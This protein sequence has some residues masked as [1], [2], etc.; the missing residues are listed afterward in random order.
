MN[1]IAHADLSINIRGVYADAQYKQISFK[2]DFVKG[3]N[4]HKNG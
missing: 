2:L 1:K 3:F 4:G